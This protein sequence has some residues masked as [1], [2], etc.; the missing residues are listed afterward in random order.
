MEGTV[1]ELKFANGTNESCERF[2]GFPLFTTFLKRM[3]R[4][5]PNH[6]KNTFSKKG[7]AFKLS[8]PRGLWSLLASLVLEVVQTLYRRKCQKAKSLPARHF[9]G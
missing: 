9:R 8:S 2:S 1:E 3:F 4:K 6:A 7:Q 5:I